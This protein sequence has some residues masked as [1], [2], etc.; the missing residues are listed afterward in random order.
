VLVS[1]AILGPNTNVQGMSTTTQAD[2]MKVSV[3]PVDNGRD[4]LKY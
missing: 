4:C 2:P 3:V 1:D